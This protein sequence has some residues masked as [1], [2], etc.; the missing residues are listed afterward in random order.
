MNC[1]QTMLGWGM[2]LLMMVSI[3][4]IAQ[5][6]QG[7]RSH[8]LSLPNW[9]PYTKNYIGISHIPD[10][11]KGIRFDLSVF[12]GYYRRKVTVPNVMYESGYHPWDASSDLKYFS[13]RH[14]LEWKDQVYT[15]ISYSYVNDNA[16][17]I[18]VNCVN[19][20]DNPQS[21]VVHMMG[22][23]HFPS[24]G[25]YQ[26]DSPL[27]KGIITVPEK[28]I[29][30]DAL[31]YAAFEYAPHDAKY[32]LLTDGKMRGEVRS[33]GYINGS[34][35]KFG[36]H[37]EDMAAYQFTTTDVLAS[38]VLWIRYKASKS[39]NLKL[40]V[41]GVDYGMVDVAESKDFATVQVDLKQLAA[42]DHKLKLESADS[43]RIMLDGF[44]VC[45]KAAVADISVKT[46]DWVYAPQVKK[47]PVKNSL[48]LKYKNVDEYYG[49]IW[50]GKQ[51][52]V[53]EWHYRYLSEEFMRKINSHTGYRFGNSKDGHYTNVFIRPINIEPQTTKVIN[54]LVC[55][56]SKEA[57]EKQ[58]KAYNGFK[59]AS[60]DYDAA[61]AK[62]P[63][64]DCI[65]AGEKYLFSQKRMYTNTLQNVV[66]P[67]Y[68]QKQYIRHHAPGRWWDCLYTWDSGFI[69]IGLAQVDEQ[70]GE[71]NLHAYLNEQEEQSAFIHHGTPLPVQHY[72]YQE[73]WNQYQSDD[74]LATNYPKLKKYYEFLSGKAQGSTTRTDLNLIKTWDYFYNSGG[75]DD[76]PPQGYV[77]WKKI[78][79]KTAPVVS[80]AH[81]I[82]IAKILKMTAAHLKLKKDVKMYDQDIEAMGKALNTYSWDEKSGYYG[83]VIEEPNAA[84]KVMTTSKGVNYNMGLG[85]ASPLIAGICNDAQQEKLINHLKTKGEIWSDQ[86][87]SAVDQSAPYYSKEGY[88]NGTVWMPHQWF[89]WKSMLDYGETDFAFKIAQN[90]LD[91]WKRE[92]E[93]TYNCFEH[94]IIESG[95]GAGWHQFSGLSSCVLSWFNAYF[96][97]GTLTT[98]YDVFISDKTV[99]EA[100][101]SLN[102]KL[103]I[104]NDRPAGVVVVLNANHKYNITWNK[105][106]VTYKEL[107]PGCLTFTLPPGAKQGQLTVAKQ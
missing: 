33:N 43:E 88:W 64:F 85:G 73:L 62:L 61:H 56:G 25:P 11:K 5:Q 4:G 68:T 92:T 14:E 54:G 70:R 93:A 34:A 86:G 10:V 3:P 12:P 91:V 80:T 20:T 106:P 96:K 63:S 90:A 48:I 23:I 57:V 9:G 8:D 15:D 97:P 1:K 19:N 28:G 31:D 27:R 81:A 55:V 69:G 44:V 26:P 60:K 105:K 100:N 84:P 75:W 103:K 76:Y 87:L 98:G 45:E 50:E 38:P 2:A 24:V 67:V 47:G 99:D 35:V 77:H 65:P 58:I 21:L 95:R 53:R 41:D 39:A 79:H 30:K 29:Y 49:I 71:E 59:D 89:F 51:S 36:G 6:K 13:Y 42:G 82:R 74:M 18:R 66:Y 32:D 101:T 17:L 40:T 83:Y 16:R 37:K 7:N 94:F 107:F 78:A 22:S 104:Y 46:I 102:A 72:L 52:E